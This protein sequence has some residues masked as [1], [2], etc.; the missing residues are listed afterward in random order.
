MVEKGVGPQDSQQNWRTQGSHAAG[1]QTALETAWPSAGMTVR[2]L[3]PDVRSM[4]RIPSA[5][6]STRA[7]NT[8]GSSA[9]CRDG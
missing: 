2:G 7:V 9:Q 8:I 6:R 1:R 3:V 5:A 4:Q